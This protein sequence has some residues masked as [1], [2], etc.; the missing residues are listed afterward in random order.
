MKP[1]PGIVQGAQNFKNIVPQHSKAL[2]VAV[3][4]LLIQF[5]TS[6]SAGET[7]TFFHTR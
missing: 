5:L 2:C 1:R 3:L 4:L 6:D 7:P